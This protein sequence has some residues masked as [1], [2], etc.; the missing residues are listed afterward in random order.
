MDW[1]WLVLERGKDR[2][3]G[4]ER[5]IGKDRTKGEEIAEESQSVCFC[6]L[7]ERIG[8]V[9]MYAICAHFPK[10]VNSEKIKIAAVGTPAPRRRF[11]CKS[12]FEYL[13]EYTETSPY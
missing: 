9:F 6:L 7:K 10:L 11:G 12:Q 13:R 5:E 8:N 4:P 3:K 2:T 1:G